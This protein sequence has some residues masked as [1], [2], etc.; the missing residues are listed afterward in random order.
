MI[1]NKY[2]IVFKS[3]SL[4]VILF[5]ASQLSAMGTVLSMDMLGCSK[6]VTAITRHCLPIHQTTRHASL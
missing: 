3:I 4:I 2:T 5:V 1:K 6:R